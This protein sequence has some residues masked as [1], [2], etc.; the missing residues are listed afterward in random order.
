MDKV[1]I[2]IYPVHHIPDGE[3]G[4]DTVECP[5]EDADAYG[6]YE[7]D[8]SLAT[9]LFDAATPEDAYAAGRLLAKLYGAVLEDRYGLG[10]AP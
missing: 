2:S 5:I 7:S 1:I 8:G 9:H 4:Y 10:D 6:V 3:G